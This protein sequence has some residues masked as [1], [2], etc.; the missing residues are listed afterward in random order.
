MNQI[1]EDD[2]GGESDG[3]DPGSETFQ[4]DIPERLSGSPLCPLSPKH[5]SSGRAS[6]CIMEERKRKRRRWEIVPAREMLMW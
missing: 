4:W 3:K 6:V 2:T 1:E 5:K